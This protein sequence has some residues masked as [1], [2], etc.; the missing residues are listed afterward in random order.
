MLSSIQLI[1]ELL[2][3]Y[4]SSCQLATIKGF[5]AVVDETYKEGDAVILYPVGAVLP[6][7]RK[8][9]E[10]IIKPIN[11]GYVT[12]TSFVEKTYRKT[13][14]K[15]LTKEL[16]IRYAYGTYITYYQFCNQDNLFMEKFFVTGRL[17]APSQTFIYS[18]YEITIQIFNNMNYVE[19]AKCLSSNTLLSPTATM[20]LAEKLNLNFVP[21]IDTNIIV[22]TPN[23]SAFTN[24]TEY[25]S[26]LFRN[27]QIMFSVPNTTQKEVNYQFLK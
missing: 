23:L 4:K 1:E 12:S 20:D 13:I 18:K 22:D 2:P 9:G 7:N 6:A 26:L 21:I 3:L 24:L 17:N 14:G 11:T 25:S 19:T 8:R 10:T 27:N 15:D 5:K 16:N